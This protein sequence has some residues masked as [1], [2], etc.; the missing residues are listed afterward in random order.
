MKL[1]APNATDLVVLGP[2]VA[3]SNRAVTL[4]NPSKK[5]VFLSDEN[6]IP[7][8]LS[9][10]QEQSLRQRHDFHTKIHSLECKVASLTAQLAI[11]SMDTDVELSSVKDETIYKPIEQAYQRMSLDRGRSC[12]GSMRWINVEKRMTMLDSQMTHSVFVGYQ[13]AKKKHLDTLR[14]EI[15][16]DVTVDLDVDSVE[17]GKQEG[18]LVRKFEELAGSMSRRY[19][20]ER[21]TRYASLRMIEEDLETKGNVDVITHRYEI[22]LDNIRSLREQ[23]ALE[24]AIREGNDNKVLEQ[25]CDRHDMM[26]KSILEAFGDPNI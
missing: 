21:A 10:V 25:V 23:I 13:D 7:Q 26:T 20:D 16:N 8:Q 17:S 5:F 19:Q 14:D 1:P 9:K 2:D 15:F 11:E 6:A 24:R 3:T 18:M 4:F 12:I 22:I